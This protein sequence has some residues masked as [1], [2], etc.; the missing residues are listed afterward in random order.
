MEDSQTEWFLS[1]PPT[2]ALGNKY[3]I[4]CLNFATLLIKN[5]SWDKKFIK[6]GVLEF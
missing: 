3:L 2:Q 6:M 1:L 5:R 4:F